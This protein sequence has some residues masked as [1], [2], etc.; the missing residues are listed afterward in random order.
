MCEFGNEI[1]IIVIV[2]NSVM[3]AITINQTVLINVR[4]LIGCLSML[5]LN[6]VLSVRVSLKL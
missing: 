3:H 4:S 1:Q 2:N 6:L 5:L